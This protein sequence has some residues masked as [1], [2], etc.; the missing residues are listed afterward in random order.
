MCLIYTGCIGRHGMPSLRLTTVN[1]M[2]SLNVMVLSSQYGG[3]LQSSDCIIKKQFSEMKG[4]QEKE[5]I[6]GVRDR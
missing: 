2:S 1:V 5:S 3:R 6:M 4:M